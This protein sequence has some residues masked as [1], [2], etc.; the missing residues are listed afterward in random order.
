M[1]NRF[2][3]MTNSDTETTLLKY[4][5]AKRSRRPG[6]S[7]SSSSPS[8]TSD[9]SV[10]SS[11]RSQFSQRTGSTVPPELPPPSDYRH[12]LLGAPPVPLPSEPSTHSSSSRSRSENR[13][14]TSRPSP[15][16]QRRCLIIMTIISLTASVVTCCLVALCLVYQLGPIFE[17]FTFEPGD[18]EACVPCSP[19][20]YQSAAN[21]DL[22]HV[23]V[24]P[25]KSEYC[26]ARNT[27]QMSSLIQKIMNRKKSIAVVPEPTKHTVQSTPVS[28]HKYLLSW[29]TEHS[30]DG[31]K[32]EKN[33]CHLRFDNHSETSREHR[34]LVSVHE[35]HMEVKYSGRYFVYSSIYLRTSND[36]PCKQLLNQTFRH[37]I[38]RDRQDSANASGCLV[39]TSHTCCDECTDDYHTSYAAGVFELKTG[40]QIFVNVGGS[41]YVEF[42]GNGTY[43]GLVMLGS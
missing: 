36:F 43:L 18:Y 10:I 34:R 27:G 1:P 16:L 28:A 11:N 26:C 5:D 30:Q 17:D 21:R 24:F 13:Q 38:M 37:F 25:D 8:E 6:D 39:E 32:C 20:S 22:F 4:V 19:D 35:K 41:N 15:F 40:D 23:K 31:R 42:E 3:G 12:R 7:Q 2:G 33:L 14:N 9:S 29:D